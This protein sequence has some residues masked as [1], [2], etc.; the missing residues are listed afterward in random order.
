MSVDVE[1][2]KHMRKQR[3]QFPVIYGESMCSTIYT[4]YAIVWR[5]ILWTV[6]ECRHV[7]VYNVDPS[8]ALLDIQEFYELTL[9][10]DGKT[11]EAKASVALEMA[12]RYESLSFDI[13]AK[14]VIARS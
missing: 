5:L 6:N 7:I 9:M 14:L 8:Q 2:T 11:N 4:T 13:I 3:S 1:L 10:D 12:S